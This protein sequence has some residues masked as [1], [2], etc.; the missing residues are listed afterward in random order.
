[1]DA[2]QEANEGPVLHEE[3][4]WI[5]LEQ[6]REEGRDQ[7]RLVEARS[8]VQRVLPR[9]GLSPSEEERA[10][11]EACSSLET[12]ERWLDQAVVAASSADALR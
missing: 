2:F 6:G 11:I 4:D 12:L 3:L 7:G 10:P 5:F 1:M 9:R 8:P